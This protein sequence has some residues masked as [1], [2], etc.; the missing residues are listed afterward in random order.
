MAPLTKVMEDVTFLSNVLP[1]VKTIN[2]IIC[3]TEQ[4]VTS[5]IISQVVFLQQ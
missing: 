2:Q 1:I 4:I 3:I 5:K